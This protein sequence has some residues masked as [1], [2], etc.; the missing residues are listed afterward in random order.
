MHKQSE[1]EAGVEFLVLEGREQ[2]VGTQEQQLQTVDTDVVAAVA[3][4]APLASEATVAPFDL[5]GPAP[6]DGIAE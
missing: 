4:A 6:A 1:A 5:V 3:V 2:L